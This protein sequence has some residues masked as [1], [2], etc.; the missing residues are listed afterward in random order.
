MFS[1]MK[2]RQGK[3]KDHPMSTKAELKQN[4][5]HQKNTKNPEKGP[6]KQTLPCAMLLLTHTHLCPRAMSGQKT[7]K[8]RSLLDAPLLSS[9]S[10]TMTH[11]LQTIQ[12]QTAGVSFSCQHKAVS[13][14]FNLNHG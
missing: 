10:L 6:L 7:S 9:R 2:Q 3:T 5:K 4:R 11:L 1:L 14:N 12:L 8:F 13:F